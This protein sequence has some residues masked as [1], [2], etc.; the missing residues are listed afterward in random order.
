MRLQEH[1]LEEKS[2][3]SFLEILGRNMD[4][5]S[6]REMVNFQLKKGR[7]VNVGLEDTNIKIWRRQW[8]PTPVLL[9]GKSHG[10]RSL[11]GGSPCDSEES[12]ITEQLHFHFSLMH[13]RR[14]WQPTPV[15]P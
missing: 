13:W 3:K 4:T 12:D 15:L 7:L 10:R 9:L 11:V 5:V 6:Q 2:I 14:K 8:H 1:D